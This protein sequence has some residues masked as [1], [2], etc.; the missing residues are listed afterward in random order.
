MKS[1]GISP[2]TDPRGWS[3]FNWQRSP[4]VLM[5]VTQVGGMNDSESPM[6]R[7]R[8]NVVGITSILV[9]GIWMAGL[10]TGQDWWLPALLVGYVAVLPLVAILFG[11]EEEASEW[12]DDGNGNASERSTERDDVQSPQTDGASTDRALQTL[13]QRYAN[14]E[15]TEAQFERKLERLLEVETVEDL[16]RMGGATD[17]ETVADDSL[18]ADSTDGGEVT[19][20]TTR[21]S[22]TASS[23]GSTT[24]ASPHGASHEGSA[25]GT[26][27][28]E[29]AD[30]HEPA[31]EE[32]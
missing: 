24:E 2:T 30:Q 25:D 22:S 4:I 10:F 27:R 14:G 12:L 17:I 13:R 26:S 29:S 32:E 15:L 31:V 16:E 18:R 5:I 3:W 20:A 21:S 1:S 19:D 9:T 11:D 6:E 8:E 7:F 28:A 23:E